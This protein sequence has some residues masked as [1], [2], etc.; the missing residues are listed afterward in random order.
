MQVAKLLYGPRATKLI[1]SDLFATKLFKY[2]ALASSFGATALPEG[3]YS[4]DNS[5]AVVFCKSHT[6]PPPPPPPPPLPP[7]PETRLHV[8]F[9]PPSLT[10]CTAFMVSFY[11]IEGFAR[12]ASGAGIRRVRVCHYPGATIS[13][14]G[15]SFSPLF[16]PAQQTRHL[17]NQ[18][19]NNKNVST[20]AHGHSAA[21][22]GPSSTENRLPSTLHNMAWSRRHCVFSSYLFS[23][24]RK[25]LRETK[26]VSESSN[27]WGCILLK[28]EELLTDLLIRHTPLFP[29]AHSHHLEAASPE[30]LH[31]L[32]HAQQSCGC[33]HEVKLRFGNMKGQ[34]HWH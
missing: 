34:W 12:Q 11:W 3:P 5:V 7:P 18:R 33:L 29:F 26:I 17:W 16:F 19:E 13:T 24:H 8:D 28:E 30:F 22:L 2:V 21:M 6:P 32:Y 20:Q 4:D 15:N 31:H 25:K 10:T 1:T 14:A 23:T 9:Q 27:R